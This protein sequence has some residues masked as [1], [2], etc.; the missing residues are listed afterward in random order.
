[1][2]VSPTQCSV[3]I[4]TGKGNKALLVF[5]G[6]ACGSKDVRVDSY[7]IA[8]NDSTAKSQILSRASG[9]ALQQAGVSI[10]ISAGTGLLNIAEAVPFV[11]P[12]AYLIGSTVIACE[13]AQ[14][15]KSDCKEY[16]ICVVELE[17]DLLK[18]DNLIEEKKT[19]KAIEDLLEE[20][21]TFVRA[22]SATNNFIQV[23]SAHRNAGALVSIRDRLVVL[24]QSMNFKIAVDL[25][26]MVQAKFDE[27][28]KL[29]QYISQLGG[30]EEVLT[31]DEK[32]R[33]VT[34]CLDD[35]H[36]L[37]VSLQRESLTSTNKLKSDLDTNYKSIISKCEMQLEE[38]KNIILASQQ[39]AEMLKIQNEILMKQVMQM[40]SMQ[41]QMSEFMSKFPLPV[42]E[43]KRL[44]TVKELQLSKI[45]VVAEMEDYLHGF[46]LK[47]RKKYCLRGC[48]VNI[49]EL[50]FQNTIAYRFQHPI[51]H[52][53][54]SRPAGSQP[55][56]ASR[57]MSKCQYVVADDEVV[58]MKSA[59]N[60]KSGNEEI[61]FNLLKTDWWAEHGDQM[62]ASSE[63]VDQFMTLF[64]EGSHIN[65]LNEF[66]EAPEEKR[67]SKLIDQFREDM[68]SKFGVDFHT[69][70]VVECMYFLLNVCS[71]TVYI[72]APIKIQGQCVGVFCMYLNPND[73]DLSEE[74]ISNLQQMSASDL[75]SALDLDNQAAK[76][77]KILEEYAASREHQDSIMKQ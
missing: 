5:M 26:N 25:K 30:L 65:F 77:A 74:E 34:E 64:V 35:P 10:A 20:G 37:I 60:V 53:L 69:T 71:S 63:L 62:R 36:R 1:M 54:L 27:E 7:Q 14:S 55:F 56:Q 12:I 42:N 58:C 31:D 24:L 45:G 59:S 76:V 66:F 6:G 19:I 50:E 15:L 43:H 8:D 68:I 57:Q 49:M 51:D 22:L 23:L 18:A 17:K 2:R 3:F 48:M 33:Q 39:Q 44:Y 4:A 11:A 70:K 13:E 41:M 75:S 72:G 67:D 46:I 29:S 21:C 73:G 40:N 16:A 38:Q 9:E 52:T 61:P 47:H 32:T 28:K